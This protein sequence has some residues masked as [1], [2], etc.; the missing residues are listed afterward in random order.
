MTTP[1]TLHPLLARQIAKATEA[2]GALDARRLYALVSEAYSQRD[3]DVRRIDRAS[4][5]MAQE[6]ADA[7][8]AL[9]TQ[10]VWFRAALDNMNHGLCLFDRQARL[11]VCNRRFREIYGLADTLDLTGLTLV[12]ILEKSPAL[13][14]ARQ[15]ER[16]ILINEHLDLDFGA[17]Y[18][19]Q[20]IWPNDRFITIVRKTIDGGGFLDTIT[21]VTESHKA[22]IRIAHMARH[23]ALTDLPNRT[24]LRE[25][26]LELIGQCRRGQQSAVLCLDLDRFKWVNDS[27]GHPLGDAL[28][29]AVSRRLRSLMRAGDFVA[30]LGGDEFAVVQHNVKSRVNPERLAQRIIAKLSRPYELQGHRVQIGVSIGIEFVD[31]ARPDADEVLRNADLALYQAKAQGRGGYCFFDAEMH[32]VATRR[33]KLECDLR[34]ALSRKQFE[35]HYQPQYDLRNKAIGGFEALVRWRHPERGMVAPGEFIAICEETGL[36]DD[37]GRFVLNKA[38][39][40]ATQW[41]AGIQISVN[42]SPI[43]FRS[44]HLVD[45]VKQ[46]IEM[47]GLAPERL[48]LEITESIMVEDVSGV[49]EQLHA[50]KRLGCHVALDDF[51]T[52]YSSLS[53]IR[54]FPFDRIKID[55]SFIKDLGASSDSLAIIR[56]V[57]GMCGSLG[58]K[59]T[60]EGVE[61]LQQL[62]ILCR[63]NCDSVQGY[64]FSRP[65]PLEETLALLAQFPG[66]EAPLAIMTRVA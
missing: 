65:V 41:H 60:A 26:L 46:A 29:I 66:S 13:A 49:L 40:D 35:V 36:I 32:E 16:R 33:R 52:G 64:L 8:A 25:R 4:H 57:A 61:T 1:G 19:L 5:L 48:E 42:L 51:G 21:D 39:M 53:Y 23:D 59:S 24:L 6:L 47:A 30:R 31:M 2:E 9:E 54:H 7:I 56:A 50:L 62:D 58:I 15:Y 37:L 12:E 17:E 14:S 28:L 27:L 22:T 44:R 11:A 3:V 38:C 34:D 20:Q 55:Q 63:E 43:Q 18:S 45:I 10:N